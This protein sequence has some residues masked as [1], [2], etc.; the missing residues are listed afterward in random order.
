[1]SETE[2][3]RASGEPSTLSR[4]EAKANVRKVTK[5]TNNS[6][7][8]LPER[9][10]SPLSMGHD[11]KVGRIDALHEML[12]DYRVEDVTELLLNIEKYHEV[13]HFYGRENTIHNVI[14]NQPYRTTHF[15]PY[16]SLSRKSLLFRYYWSAGLLLFTIAFFSFALAFICTIPFVTSPTSPS[17]DSFLPSTIVGSILSVVNISLFTLWPLRSMRK[18]HQDFGLSIYGEKRFGH[19]FD[20][21]EQL[22]KEEEERR[23]SERLERLSREAEA[24]N[25]KLASVGKDPVRTITHS[26]EKRHSG[27]QETAAKPNMSDIKADYDKAFDIITSYELD[28][29]K[30]I[31]YPAF[32]DITVNEVKEMHLLLKQ[33]GQAIKADDAVTARDHVNKL[34]VA[35]RAA[36]RVATKRAWSDITERE[37]KDLELAQN[38]I[39][40]ANDAGNTE[41][42]RAVLYERLHKVID[43][44]NSQHRIVPQKTIALLEEQSRKEIAQSNE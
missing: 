33:S 42:M 8:S 22:V 19:T 37:Q 23:E 4:E 15:A 32:N 16:Y 10:L 1:M 14:F 28:I 34:T 44:L 27:V 21:Y 9:T 29:I 25:K 41:E 39:T 35:V 30:A 12:Q 11:Y 31:K 26:T 6:L 3:I 7:R 2:E 20:Y 24:L 40:Q 13:V 43:R 17:I 18:N 38:L 5:T 36:E